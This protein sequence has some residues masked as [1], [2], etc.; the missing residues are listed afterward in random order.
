[1]IVTI[2]EDAKVLIPN[3]EHQNFTE[4]N[5]VITKDTQVHGKPQNVKGLR[6]GEPFEYKLFL[7]NENK[8]IYL[9]KIKNMET[10]STSGI[11]TPP[12]ISVNLKQNVLAK[13]HILGA[14]GGGL[15]GLGWAKYKKHEMKKVALATLV[16]AVAGFIVGKVIEHRASVKI[17]K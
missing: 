12:K 3:Q 8:L 7:T 5:E 14:I 15:V 11:D 10:E 17:A 13:P 2:I 1:M 4:T 9:N 6:R 16:G